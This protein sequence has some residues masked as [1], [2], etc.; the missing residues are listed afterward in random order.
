MAHVAEAGRQRR[1]STSILPSACDESG[2]FAAVIG[3]KWVPHGINKSG[4]AKETNP[5]SLEEAEV[6][7]WNRMPF[8]IP[9]S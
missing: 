3:F 5:P 6:I 1:T 7:F 4:T 8:R 2:R 9:H